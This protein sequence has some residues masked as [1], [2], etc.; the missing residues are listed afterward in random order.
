MTLEKWQENNRL[1]C[2]ALTPLDCFSLE[3]TWKTNSEWILINSSDENAL[4]IN[5]REN[6]TQKLQSFIET[7]SVYDAENKYKKTLF[8]EKNFSDP[9]ANGIEFYTPGN[10]YELKTYP[11]VSDKGEKFLIFKSIEKTKYQTQYIKN[12]SNCFV[13]IHN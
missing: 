2:I 5:W 8:G 6:L 7:H 3:E 4:P 1:F 10:Y 12:K 11:G 13:I 9:S